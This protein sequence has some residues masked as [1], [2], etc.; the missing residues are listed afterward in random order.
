MGDGGGEKKDKGTVIYRPATPSG[1]EPKGMR[2]AGCFA[3]VLTAAVAYAGAV[4]WFAHRG[5]AESDTRV[6][7]IETLALASF[8]ARTEGGAVGGHM[9]PDAVRAGADMRSILEER[10]KRLSGKSFTCAVG[11]A[12][13]WEPLKAD[14]RPGFAAVPPGTRVLDMHDAATCH[15]LRAMHGVDHFLRV[16]ATF[17]LENTGR[18]AV[19]VRL[20]A[21]VFAKDATV[22]WTDVFTETLEF[23]DLP[24]SDPGHANASIFAFRTAMFRAADRLAAALEPVEKP[25]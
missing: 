11:S 6:R 1:A 4:A 22:T 3:F 15:A 16:L 5:R 25:K 17:S 14:A 19:V 8:G 23:R 2:L 18:K 21:S 13:M 12:S 20:E 7:Q 9:P 24:A 10:L